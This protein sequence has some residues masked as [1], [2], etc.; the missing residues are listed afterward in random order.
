[1]TTFFQYS[2]L[3]GHTFLHLFSV[4]GS[5]VVVLSI[6]YSFVNLTSS[7]SNHSKTSLYHL[8]VTQS[9]FNKYV[10]CAYCVLGKG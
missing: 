6:Y 3:D 1:M 9:S 7:E 5:Q 4:S 2:Y 8:C 10:L